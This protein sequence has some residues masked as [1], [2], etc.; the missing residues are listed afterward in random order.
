[1]NSGALCSFHFTRHTITSTP[2][3]I[4][5]TIGSLSIVV[6]RTS[7]LGAWRRVLGY[8]LRRALLMMV[9]VL[10]IS[11]MAFVIIQLPPGDYLSTV[12]ANL[13]AR[14]VPVTQE[15]IRSSRTSTG[16]TCR[17]TPST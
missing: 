9:T 11:V 2:A 4:P 15:M 6:E 10:A 12:I 5:T 3:W 17:C 16:S 13:Q 1:M 7:W 14:G 8:L